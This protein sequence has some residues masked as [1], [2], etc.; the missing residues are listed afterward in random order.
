MMEDKILPNSQLGG[1]RFEYTVHKKNFRLSWKLTKQAWLLLRRDK[2]ILLFPVFAILLFVGLIGISAAGILV[3]VPISGLGQWLSELDTA[4]SQSAEILQ[5]AVVLIVYLLAYFSV[6]FCEVALVST[7]G[8]RLAGRDASILYGFRTSWNR[9]GK[10]AY[11]ASVDASVGLFLSA[12]SE[13]IKWIG[14]W[15]SRT[16]GATWSVATFFVIPILVFEPKSVKESL[17]YSVRIFRG[18][19]RESLITILS[20]NVFFS[21]IGA[22]GFVFF[23]TVFFIAITYFPLDGSSLLSVFG[24]VVLL[25]LVI[26]AILN[27]AFNSLLRLV[28]YTFVTQGSLPEQLDKQF[29]TDLVAHHSDGEEELNRKII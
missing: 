29:F 25:W 27:S 18:I 26:L 1:G 15:V 17:Q 10:I 22:V 23:T 14:R 19:W 21:V 24:G 4:R 13:K 7:I 20:V 2:K 16:L 12:L 8:N 3:V 9:I 5:L 11:W 28:L 6:T